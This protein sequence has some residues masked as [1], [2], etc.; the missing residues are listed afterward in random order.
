MENGKYGA[1]KIT[2]AFYYTPKGRMLDK[3]G[4]T[5]D[6]EVKMTNEEWQKLYDAVR[7]KRIKENISY[8]KVVLDPKLDKQLA[9]AIEVLQGK[10][11][12]EG[13]EKEQKSN[14]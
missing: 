2:T 1:V 7:E 8:G 3:K 14:K 13:E 12:P 11:H 6:I 4:L 9:V 5:P 10:Y